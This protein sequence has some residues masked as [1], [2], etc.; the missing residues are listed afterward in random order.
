MKNTTRNIIYITLLLLLSIIVYGLQLYLF[1]GNPYYSTLFY[2]LQDL[3]FLPVEVAM[4]TFIFQRFLHKQEVEKQTKK[5][6]VIIST[7]FVEIGLEI[8]TAIS[9]CNINR[10]EIKEQIT[11]MELSYKRDRGL[12]KDLQCLKFQ[13]E[14]SPDKIG[15]LKGILVKKKHFLVRM[16][17]NDHLLEHDSFTDTLWAVFHVADELQ[18]RNVDDLSDEDI[19]HLCT[20]LNRAYRGLVEEWVLYVHHLE[21]EYPYL[22]KT[23]IKRSPFH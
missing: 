18:M 21:E 13:M 17:E 11:D 9:D 4:V 22:H 15:R 14:A 8:I 19:A 3:A 20:D 1:F 6:N 12:R 16:L 23:A 7:F 10:D 2:F 5:T